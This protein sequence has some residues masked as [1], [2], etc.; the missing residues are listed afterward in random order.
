M[1]I[2]SEE[3]SKDLKDYFKYMQHTGTYLRQ[4]IAIEEKYY[5]YGGTPQMV[6]EEISSYINSGDSK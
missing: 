5:C 1:E 4:L 3:A 2:T 6:S